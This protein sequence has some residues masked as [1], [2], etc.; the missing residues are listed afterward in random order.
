MTAYGLTD[1]ERQLL[2]FITG[3]ATSG[4]RMP[5]F[6]EMA[7]HLGVKAKSHVHRIIVSLERKGHVKRIPG[8][9]RA[10]RIDGVTTK[11]AIEHVLANCELS[12]AARVELHRAMRAH[13]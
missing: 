13:A 7:A 9:A 8:H 1:R 12:F 10:I 6:E 3:H 5:S 2:D 11:S 4:T